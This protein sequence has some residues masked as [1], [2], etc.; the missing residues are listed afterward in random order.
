MREW[1]LSMARLAVLLAC[2]GSI[3]ACERERAPRGKDT[4]TAV[5]PPQPLPE[6][7]EAPGSRWD[8]SLGAVFVVPMGEPT[9]GALIVPRYSFGGELDSVKWDPR[10]FVGRSFEV[11]T[12]SGVVSR[13]QV[14][15]VDTAQLQDCAMWPTAQF[16]PESGSSIPPWRVGFEPGKS[17]LA[18]FDSLANLSSADSSRLVV[19]LARIASGLPGDTVAALRGVPYVVR[20]AHRFRLEDGTDAVLAEIVRTLNQ[21]AS[22]EQERLLLIVE[23]D[24]VNAPVEATRLTF[25]ERRAG[26]E[27]NLEATELL[28]VVN[29]RGR[30]A[31]LLERAIGDGVFYSMLERVRRDDARAAWRPGWRSPYAGC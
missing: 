8:A 23:R 5:E 28:A 7:T 15:T 12:S 31:L 20:Q 22:P 13:V 19:A 14:A 4:A 11:A 26:T 16:T 2:V 10:M 9:H 6:S 29:V 18:P 25:A 21:E 30:A 17:S 24:S 1:K 3:V 27:E